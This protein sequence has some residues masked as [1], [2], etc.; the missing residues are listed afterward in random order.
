MIRVER[1]PRPRCCSACGDTAET[2]LVETRSIAGGQARL[3]L[4]RKRCLPLMRDMTAR[5]SNGAP[6]DAEERV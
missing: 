4:C 5:M 3:R 1:E 2:V 6:G